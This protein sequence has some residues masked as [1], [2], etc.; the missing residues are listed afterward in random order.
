MIKNIKSVQNILKQIWSILNQKQRSGTIVVFCSM[1]ISS[2]VELL[3]VS[4][5]YPFIQMM[6]SMTALQEKWYIRL[7]YNILPNV[8]IKEVM[9]IFGLIIILVYILKNVFL[10]FSAYIQHVYAAKFQCEVSTRMF[11]AYL[12][13]PYQ[14]FLNTNSGE[15]VRGITSD[16][17]GVYQIILSFFT[18]FAELLTVFVLGIFLFITDWTLALG[19]MLLMSLCF[20]TVILGFK[21]KMKEAGINMWEVKAL[22]NQ[23]GYQAINGIKE[24]TVLDRRDNFVKQFYKTALI[25]KKA[26]IIN[27]VVSACPDRILEGICIGGFMGIV[28]IKI[29]VGTD[30]NTFVPVLGTFA[31]GAFRILPSVSKISSRV[32]S[33]IFRLSSLQ[34]VYENFKEEK[35]GEKYLEELTTYKNKNEKKVRFTKELELKNINWRYQD[36]K[37]NVLQNASLYINKGESVAFIG[38]SGAGKTTLADIIMGLLKPQKGTIEMDGIDI[39]TVPHQWAKII[40]YVP[41][42]VFLIDDTIRRNVAFGLE[43]DEISDEK[44]WDRHN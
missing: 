28:C 38:S 11:A 30:L 9:L 43:E 36:A 7:I 16:I 6:L 25:E 13:R 41:Q 42:S 23:Y 44:V 40:G 12:K 4:A 10:I 2:I 33:I 27:G 35:E 3:G 31:M 18:I 39:F 32:N 8:G 5:I 15:I 34:N 37:E 22:K 29:A 26:S 19:S 21:S 1:L 20:L 24:I 14:F 17:E